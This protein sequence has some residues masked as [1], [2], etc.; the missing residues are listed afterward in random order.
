[1]VVSKIHFL[2]CPTDK[3]RFKNNFRGRQFCLRV[4]ITRLGKM[5]KRFLLKEITPNKITQI[6]PCY[7]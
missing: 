7:V 2:L 3:T 5:V 1:M 4:K 6:H